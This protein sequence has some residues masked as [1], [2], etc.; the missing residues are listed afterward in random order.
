LEAA[1]AILV[2]HHHKDHCKRATVERLKH[3]EAL[4]LAPKSCVKELS[5]DIRII[6]PGEEVAF[7]RATIRAIE[8][9]NTEQGSSTKK[10]HHKGNGVGYLI[11]IDGRTIY[12]AGDTDFVPEMRGL[13]RV[14]V[15]L[16]PIGGTYTMD[17]REAVEATLA[18]EPRA[19]VPMHPLHVDCTSGVN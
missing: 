12:H 10:V 15:A 2:T 17:I 3:P 1:D 6:K 14:D 8:A 7:E 18:I 19:V 5:K 13:G 9:Y 16:L 4:V 11:T